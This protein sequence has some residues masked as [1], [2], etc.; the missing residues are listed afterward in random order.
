MPELPEVEILARHL[1][2]VLP[3][4]TIAAVEFARERS[5]RPTTRRDLE[6]HLVAAQFKGVTRRGKYLLFDLEASQPRGEFQAVGHLGMTG[7][8]Y[9]QP[10]R[11][12]LP[13]HTALAL[14]LNEGC[15]FV[16]ADTR[17]FGRF[18]LDGSAIQAL[19]PEPLGDGFC[20]E[21]LKA[22]LRRSTQAI[23]I[24]LLDQSLVA[25]VGNIYA[26]EALFLARISPR[27][28]ARRL[29]AAR[30]KS[31]VRAVREVLR[32]AIQLG[33]TIPLAW[34]R[35]RN[36]DRLFYYGRETEADSPAAERF[37]VYDRAGEP[38]RRCGHAIRRIVQ[39][40]RSTYYCS[41][42]QK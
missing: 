21:Y 33:S 2:Q 41:H 29:N 28:S 10:A 8:M 35:D 26:S 16:F 13:K 40:A 34:D 15:R 22:A 31:L 3:G 38:C 36:G 7:R 24:R 6:T 25:G 19:G 27:T 4:R 23:K 32:R 20:P 14:R 39:A 30:L 11:D 1:N 5:L 42:C 17:Y 18:T 37:K 12:P 9:L